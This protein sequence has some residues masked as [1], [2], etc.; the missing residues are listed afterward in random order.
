MISAS[1]QRLTQPLIWFF[2]ALAA[3]VTGLCVVRLACGPLT[4]LPHGRSTGTLLL[5]AGLA[6]AL[7]ALFHTCLIAWGTNGEEERHAIAQPWLH[8]Y[9]W[10]FLTYFVFAAAALLLA[11]LF[12]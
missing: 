1:S 3:V 11:I 6:A 7:Q 9:G 8:T 5:A 4:A 2:V 10:T 12:G